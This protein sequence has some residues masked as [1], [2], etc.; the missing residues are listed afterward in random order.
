MAIGGKEFIVDYDDDPPTLKLDVLVGSPNSKVTETYSIKAELDTGCDFT[1]IPKALVSK[2]K[3]KW[4]G[5][6]LPLVGYDEQEDPER[7]VKIYHAKIIIEGVDE[8]IIEVGVA[9]SAEWG[10]I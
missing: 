1:F 4:S 10:V 7:R 8:A 6:D 2:L 9:G 3:L 5:L